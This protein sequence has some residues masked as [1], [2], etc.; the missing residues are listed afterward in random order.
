MNLTKMHKSSTITHRFDE[1]NS[2][3]IIMQ[4]R[5]IENPTIRVSKSHIGK[6]GEHIVYKTI[7]EYP[8]GNPVSYNVLKIRR[9]LA[10]QW[11]TDGLEYL[12]ASERAM[13]REGVS[14][15]PSALLVYPTIVVENEKDPQNPRRNR[16]LQPDFVQMFPKLKGY[17]DLTLRWPQLKDPFIQE[18]IITLC[19]QAESIFQQDHFGVDPIGIAALGDNLQGLGKTILE[20][21]LNKM[22]QTPEVVREFVRMYIEAG[23]AGQ[24]R[25]ILVANEDR[26]IE[27]DAA[28]PYNG[29]GERMQ[30]TK[31]GRIILADT[32]VHDLR[33][34]TNP[35]KFIP[36][37]REA[38]LMNVLRRIP[39]Q[40]LTSPLHYLMWGAMIELLIHANPTLEN[41]PDMPFTYS[42][43]LLEQVQRD[44]ARRAARE[45]VEMMVT[46]F[47]RYEDSHPQKRTKSF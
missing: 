24:M 1:F 44:T 29:T 11:Q 13:E 35:M 32:G 19:K 45:M 36:A 10:G 30:I 6:G 47:D 21:L 26:F 42:N 46:H 17:D 20:M 4:P 25:N 16:V 5:I 14:R 33:P 27:G 8:D 31:K 12:E 34:T 43:N 41:R 2:E 15:L 40:Q 23:V 39:A 3:K 7:D 18:Q 28:K 22:P 37:V 38:G 9:A